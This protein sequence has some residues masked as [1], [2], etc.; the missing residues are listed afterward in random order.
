MGILSMQRLGLAIDDRAK[1]RA[2]DCLN[3]ITFGQLQDAPSD[4]EVCIRGFL[5]ER[6]IRNATMDSK[7]GRAAKQLYI[8]DHPGYIFQKKQIYA[9]GQMLPANVWRESMRPYLERALEGILAS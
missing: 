9:N 5:S 4:N 1:M 3:E 8:K 6:G 7:L 2:K